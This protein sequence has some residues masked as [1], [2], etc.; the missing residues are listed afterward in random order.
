MPWSIQ[1]EVPGIHGSKTLNVRTDIEPGDFLSQVKANLDLSQ[2]E[3]EYGC[4][5]WKVSVTVHN[6]QSV[7]DG[8][9]L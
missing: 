2:N 3:L 4:F 7:A 6:V 8:I 1:V 9:Q 5:F